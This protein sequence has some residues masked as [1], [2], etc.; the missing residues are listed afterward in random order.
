MHFTL[1]FTHLKAKKKS[2]RIRAKSCPWRDIY[3]IPLSYTF[4]LDVMQYCIAA[5]SL[6]WGEAQYEHTTSNLLDPIFPFLTHKAHQQYCSCCAHNYAT[7]RFVGK[8]TKPTR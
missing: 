4:H 7:K 5:V 1:Y 3:Y 2:F 8:S 6:F